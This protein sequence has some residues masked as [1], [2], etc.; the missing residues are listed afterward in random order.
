[1]PMAMAMDSTAPNAIHTTLGIPGI[2]YI[3]HVHLP[4]HR[5]HY[6]AGLH[7][8]EDHMPGTEAA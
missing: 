5:F 6:H 2:L 7:A 3:Q 8:G 1:M 4:V